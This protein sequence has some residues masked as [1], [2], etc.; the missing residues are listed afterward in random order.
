M[1]LV[2]L[3]TVKRNDWLFKVSQFG[4]NILVV[5]FSSVFAYSI[6]RFFSSEE[7]AS[8]WIEYLIMQSESAKNDIPNS[9]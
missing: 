5:G 7:M 4:G 9:Q 6:C 8:N 1:K 2:S 3:K